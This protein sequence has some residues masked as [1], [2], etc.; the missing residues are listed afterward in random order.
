MKRGWEGS[1]LYVTRKAAVKRV[2]SETPLVRGATNSAT[3]DEERQLY[4]PQAAPV[5]DMLNISEQTYTLFQKKKA[6]R[7]IRVNMGG[8]GVGGCKCRTL[9][10]H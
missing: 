6:R 3:Y 9:P 10:L 7:E 4:T 2:T 8:F 5:Q 1:S